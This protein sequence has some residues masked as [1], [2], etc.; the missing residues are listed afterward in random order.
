MDC[1]CF[2]YSTLFS[3][4]STGTQDSCAEVSVLCAYWAIPSIQSS[5][6]C[7][8]LHTSVRWKAIPL[9]SLLASCRVP[10]VS[11]TPCFCFCLLERSLGFLNSTDTW[12]IFHFYFCWVV[13]EKSNL[14]TTGFQKLLWFHPRIPLLC[15]SYFS[16]SKQWVWLSCLVY[17][18]QASSESGSTV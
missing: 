11:C 10:T 15:F 12:C 9:L 5:E 7:R 8:T 4:S 18:S 17:F 3:L 6:Y 16:Q 1:C 14:I 13:V 2:I